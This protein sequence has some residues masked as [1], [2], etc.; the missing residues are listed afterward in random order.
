M[1]II[2]LLYIATIDFAVAGTSIPWITADLLKKKGLEAQVFEGT[3]IKVTK[4]YLLDGH[5]HQITDQQ[6]RK[7]RD[8]AYVSPE[9][10][11]TTYMRIR[12]LHRFTLKVNRPISGKVAKGDEIEF[13]IL[14][15][16]DSMCPHYLAFPA[17]NRLPDFLPDP[18]VWMVYHSKGPNGLLKKTH[19][20][21]SRADWSKLKA[22]NKSAHANPLPAE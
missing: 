2:L 1:K 19:A 18:N 21:L 6:L 5:E 9:I 12:V 14:D 11:K 16:V 17:K 13:T 8:E 7:L 4:S 15:H 20:V 10:E 3:I 22:A